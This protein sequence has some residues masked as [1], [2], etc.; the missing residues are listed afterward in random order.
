MSQNLMRCWCIQCNS[1]ETLGTKFGFFL[2]VCIWINM[3][4]TTVQYGKCV[5]CLWINTT[6]ENVGGIYLFGIKQVILLNMFKCHVY[7]DKNSFLTVLFPFHLHMNWYQKAK[8]E[9]SLTKQFKYYNQESALV[10]KSC[11]EFNVIILFIFSE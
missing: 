8:K 4:S 1:T 6:W 9:S 2:C 11:L 3:Y 10:A 7:I 5:H